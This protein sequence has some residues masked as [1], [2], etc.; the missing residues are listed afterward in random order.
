MLL[1][2]R[3]AADHMRLTERDLAIVGEILRWGGLPLMQIGAWYFDADRTAA[4]RL[5]KLKQAG[6]LVSVREGRH[7]VITATRKG[8]TLRPDLRLPW[9]EGPWQ[10]IDHHLAVVELAS[11]LLEADQHAGWITERELLNEQ[12]RSAREADGRLRAGLGRRP[13]G[14]LVT[15]S[16]EWTAIE[17]ELHRKSRL[18]YERIMSWYLA[19][20]T[21]S[22]RTVRWYVRRTALGQRLQSVID[23]FALR[24]LVFVRQLPP[25]VRK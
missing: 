13:D 25:G 23:Q 20:P 17:V 1:D 4:N 21:G 24:N 8:A 3:R 2:R 12:L 9:R 6:Y 19:Q 10:S 22:Y 18:V 5:T 15:G 14:V 16:G 11:R 7:V